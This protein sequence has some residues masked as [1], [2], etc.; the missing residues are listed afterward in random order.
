MKSLRNEKFLG[1]DAIASCSRAIHLFSLRIAS[2]LW[3]SHFRHFSVLCRGINVLGKDGF[4]D[5]TISDRGNIAQA[6]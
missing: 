6:R 5:L 4:S 1:C 2:F 3:W